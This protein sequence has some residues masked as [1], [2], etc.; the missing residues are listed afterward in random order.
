MD[1]SFH[2]LFAGG[3]A[4]RVPGARARLRVATW[5]LLHGGGQQRTPA[6]AIRIAELAPD[7]LVLTEFRAARSS[8][9]LA[10]LADAGLTHV[11]LAPGP[12]KSNRVCVLSRWA[13]ED[14]GE[15]RRVV[16]TSTSARARTALG[17]RLLR[18]R[19][20]APGATLAVLGAHVPDEGDASA[21]DA[22]WA[23]VVA[24]ARSHA[25]GEAIL[26]GD[27]NTSRPGVDAD[28]PGQ[29]CTRRLG[30]LETL[31]FRDAWRAARPGERADS[32]VGP[33][34]ERQ[35]IDG[36]WLSAA[37]LRGLQSACYDGVCD[38]ERASDHA[39][40]WA[41]FALPARVAEGT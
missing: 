23:G 5:N 33:R 14:D 9:L 25:G 27:F 36:V 30:E 19:V 20:R 2:N 32:W 37:L 39:L 17:A 22:C 16:P 4:A 41:D 7:V 29:T 13:L 15:A 38:G 28:R 35:R 31:G 24:W 34:G 26:A 12:E 3:G 1:P 11:A 6:Q 18:V 40:C 8:Q 10:P 21:R